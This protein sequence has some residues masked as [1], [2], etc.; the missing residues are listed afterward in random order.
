MTPTIGRGTFYVRRLIGTVPV[1]ADGSAHFIA[2]AARDISFNLLDD[3]GQVIQKMGST[4]QIT[5]GGTESCIG[6]H[7]PRTSA[8]ASRPAILLAAR[9]PPSTPQRP[10]WGTQGI[11]DYVRVVQPV[12]DKHCIRCHSGASPKAGLDLSGNKTRYFNMSYDMLI[13][14]GY[15]HHIPMN[16]ADHDLTTPKSNGSHASRIARHLGGTASCPPV[17]P[18][19]RQRIYTWIDANVPYYHTYEYT[20]GSINGARDR[21]FANRLDG[22][23]RKEF[24]PVFRRRCFDCHKRSVDI[25]DAWL[26]RTIITVT[27]RVWTDTT[28]MDQGLQSEPAVAV[29]GPEYRINLTHPE[30][31]QMLTAPLASSAGGLGLCRDQEGNPIFRT[32]DDP[33]YQA[34]LSALRQGKRYMGVHPGIDMLP[35]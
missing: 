5:P 35:P 19:D 3:Q 13:D 33:D 20:D 1:E 15:V 10:D 23:F 11:I 6:C 21:W 31:S 16:G 8:L 28:L 30:W 18:E 7:E 32:T 14:R 17:P 2:P 27:S 12:W 26:G 9:R 4:T 34:M 25:S 22:W 29:F 24:D